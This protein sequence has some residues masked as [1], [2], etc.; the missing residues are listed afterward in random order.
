[1]ESCLAID[2]LLQVKSADLLANSHTPP[3]SALVL[4]HSVGP[5]GHFNSAIGTT[6]FG[7]IGKS[8]WSQ[9]GKS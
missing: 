8:R 4:V 9:T 6:T 3:S 5:N 7:V 1:M 2:P